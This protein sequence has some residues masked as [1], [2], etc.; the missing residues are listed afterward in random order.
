MKK[1]LTA[2]FLLCGVYAAQSQTVASCCARASSTE[3]FAMLSADVDFRRSHA[4]PLPFTYAEA[5]GKWVDI[6]VADG[7]KARIYEIKNEKPATR[8]VLVFHEWWGLND[9]ILRESDRIFTALGNVNVVAID[10]Y[11]GVVATEKDQASKL[12]GELKTERAQAIVK[13]VY[14]YIGPK[15]KVATMGWCMGGGWSLQAALI[16]GK[17]VEAAVVYY[18]FP[19]KDVE[20]LKTLHADVLM[21]W[22]DKDKWIN[23]QVV[24][25]FK[26]N[27]A[28]AKKSLQVETYPADH[29]FAN[30]S[31]PGYE[32]EMADDAFAKAMKFIGDRW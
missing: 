27:M 3:S 14:K 1:L 7:K 8:T 16:G 32:K 23:R 21:V 9:Y 20:K 22:P 30:P 26:A 12:M 18:G 13:A 25:E 17:Q 11:D 5:Q 2:T 29:A 24:D 6:E 15:Q 4:D 28:T 10:L 31:N 19:E